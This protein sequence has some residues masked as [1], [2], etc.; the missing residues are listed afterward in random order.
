MPTW[1]RMQIIYVI[2][3]LLELLR[4]EDNSELPV[5]NGHLRIP[6]FSLFHSQTPSSLPAVFQTMRRGLL[7]FGGYETQRCRQCLD[8][9]ENRTPHSPLQCQGQVVRTFYCA[10]LC[11]IWNSPQYCISIVTEVS[12]FCILELRSYLIRAQLFGAEFFCVWAE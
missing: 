8:T 1:L 7:R 4:L 3:S 12:L 5:D 2:W 11:P 10:A 6:G 9:V